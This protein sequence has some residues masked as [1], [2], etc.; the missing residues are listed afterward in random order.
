MSS[1]TCKD[2][3]TCLPSVMLQERSG[4][5]ASMQSTEWIRQAIT[6]GTTV[7]NEGVSTSP[8]A[9]RTDPG[10][11]TVAIWKGHEATVALHQDPEVSLNSDA[12]LPHES[13]ANVASTSIEP[14]GPE[15]PVS[16][17]AHGPVQ[18]GVY[19]GRP[20]AW[21]NRPSNPRGPA[22]W[23]DAVQGA[24]AG[25]VVVSPVSGRPGRSECVAPEVLA[26]S[27]EVTDDGMPVQS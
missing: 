17:R 10:V 13:F 21:R 20:C 18:R 8:S 3:L 19:G 12:S 2:V 4:R 24:H 1:S 7:G 27:V 11:P 23:V 6:W 16:L 15:L 5:G 22:W 14:R 25:F 26:R 9:V